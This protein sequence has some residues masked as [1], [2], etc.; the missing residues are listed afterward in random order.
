MEIKI[1]GIREQDMDI[2]L[3]RK[4]AQEKEFVRK[5]FLESKELAEKG[6]DKAEFDVVKVARSVWAEEGQSDVEAVLTV[7]GKTVA[8][9]IE[10][11]IDA[12][13]QPKQAERYFARGDKAVERGDYDEY[14]VFIVAPEAYL[15]RNAEAEKYPN[16][17]SYE[18]VLA[19][20]E[21]EFERAIIESALKK[22]NVS[23]LPRS[24]AVTAFWNQ[25]Y[26]YVEQNYPKTFKLPGKKGLERSGQPGQWITISFAKPYCI[27]IKS[28]RGFV[29][30]EIGGYGDKFNKF[31]NRNRKLIND[32]KLNIQGAARSLAIRRYV[33][34]IDFTQPF[35]SQIPYLKEA[36]DAAKELR[37][38]IPYLELK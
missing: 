28:D 4:L 16:S 37:D 14:Y 15:K 6:Y 27:E 7:D 22:V 10:N 20:T 21:D 12:P 31:Y 18:A 17:V 32:E 9:L 2:L 36:F 33:N 38:L 30:L 5:F 3:V 11:K 35:D 26:D 25:L 34:K 29:D 1:A 8:L 24:E 19:V 23:S 13:A